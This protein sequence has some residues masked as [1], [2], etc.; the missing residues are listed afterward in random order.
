MNPNAEELATLYR[1]WLAILAQRRTSYRSSDECAAAF[2]AWADVLG[3]RVP[4]L[5]DAA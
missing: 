5:K 2:G 3:V 4:A 1:T